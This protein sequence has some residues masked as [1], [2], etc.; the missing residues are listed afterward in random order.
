MSHSYQFTCQDCSRDCIVAVHVDQKPL[1][2]ICR[3]IRLNPS[4]PSH[5]QASLRRRDPMTTK[6][7]YPSKMPQDDQRPSVQV[8][9][10]ILDGVRPGLIP[11]MVR[12]TLA[13]KIAKAVAFV[14]TLGPSTDLALS[15]GDYFL[16]MTD[17]PETISALAAIDQQLTSMLA[18]LA[19]LAARRP[20]GQPEPQRAQE[21]ANGE[22]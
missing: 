11:P 17:K 12:F 18:R 15:L 9:W 19:F 3:V 20:K 13:D 4:M 6:H 14:D 21:P 8:A 10:R 22:R 16:A 2:W 1:C 5:L 7:T